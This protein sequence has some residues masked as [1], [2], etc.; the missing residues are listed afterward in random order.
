MSLQNRAL[1]PLS[2]RALYEKKPVVINTVIESHDSSN[3]S[4]WEFD[5]PAILYVPVGDLGHRP[6]GLLIVGCQRDHWYSED[7][8]AYAHTLGF[9]LAPLVAAMR[10]RLGRLTEAETEVAHLLSCGLSARE[11]AQAIGTDDHRARLLVESV[12]RKFQSLTAADLRFPPI[13]LK[14]MSW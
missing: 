7:E 1:M 4:D 10:G 8:V 14:R 13:Q 11:I 2:R 5:W 6:I 3:D 9:S 12:T